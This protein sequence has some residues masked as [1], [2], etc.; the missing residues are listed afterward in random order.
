M[1]YLAQNIAD[2]QARIEAPLLATVPHAPAEPEQVAFDLVQ[3]LERRL[4]VR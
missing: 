1:L 4:A 3:A 2:L